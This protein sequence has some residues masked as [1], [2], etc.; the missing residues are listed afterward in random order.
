MRIST[1]HLTGAALKGKCNECLLRE[2][3]EVPFR[4]NKKAKIVIV[5]ESP[6]RKELDEGRPFVGDAGKLLHKH[7]RKAGVDIKDCYIANSA[8]CLID[9]KQLSKKKINEILKCCRP[10]I[11]RV[12]RILKPKLV[13]CLGEIALTQIMRRAKLSDYRG[14]FTYCKEFN[15]EVFTTYHPAAL[16]Y[17]RALEPVFASDLVRLGTYIHNGFKAPDSSVGMDYEET[18]SIAH[19]LNTPHSRKSPILVGHDVET[20]ELDWI[21]SNSFFISHSYSWS[22]GKARQVF[23]HERDDENPDFT[24]TLSLPRKQTITVGVRRSE[25]FDDKLREYAEFVEDPYILKFMHNGNFDHH[26]ILSLFR[27]AG[28]PTPKLRGYFADTQILAQLLDENVYAKASLGLLETSFL[29]ET[30][31]WKKDFSKEHDKKHMILV[32]RQS[33]TQYAC[34]DSDVTRQVGL[35]LAEKI[36]AEPKLRRYFNKFAMPAYALGLFTIEEYGVKLDQ[37]KISKVQKEL[38][39]KRDLWSERALKCVSDEVKDQHRDRGLHLTRKDLLIDALFSQEGYGLEVKRK[40]KG[41]LPSTDKDAFK[42]IK[43]RRGVHRG[44]RRL[45]KCYYEWSEYNQLRGTFLNQ[46]QTFMR[47]D[48]RLHT[49]YSIT[50]AVSGRVASASPNLMNLPKHSEKAPII[51]QLTHARPGF[52][53]LEADLSQGELRIIAHVSKDPEM[54]RVYQN[55]EDIHSSTA[56]LLD[57]KYDSLPKDKQKDVRF[58]SKSVNFGFVYG[59]QA[60]TFK[61]YAW[62][63]FNLKISMDKAEEW[64]YLFFKKYRNIK[65]YHARVKAV[66][67]RQGYVSTLLGR[68]RRLPDVYSEHEWVSAEAERQ[69]I[70]VVIQGTCSDIALMSLVE[71]VRDN[72]FDSDRCIPVLFIHDSLT[73][74]VREDLVS[75]YWIRIKQY[76]ENPPLERDFGLKLR[77]PLVAEAAVGPNSRDLVDYVEM[78]NE[79]SKGGKA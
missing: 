45:V 10:N 76:M 38:E 79:Q 42:E 19:L 58:R 35:I 13:V 4:G 61:K 16:L 14:L 2:E 12:L 68:K 62:S 70:N 34:R 54:L 28:V 65:N 77:V 67:R 3:I 31:N 37:D 47:E 5:G 36:R 7:L 29:S 11:E 48:G 9:K 66:L 52:V 18:D 33:M 23:F 63:D 55:N 27:K 46:L 53:L 25:E 73:F 20:Q 56:R 60:Y 21:G 30:S 40:T 74:E 17:R 1:F 64:R 44:A 51:R 59:M 78:D 72:L 15:T 75:D 26:H 22:P 43:E 6:G 69:A 8:R 50:T 49:S 57:K 32:D 39:K 24:I 71:M 41:G